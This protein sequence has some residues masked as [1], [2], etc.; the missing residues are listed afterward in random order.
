MTLKPKGAFNQKAFWR[1]VQNCKADLV[2]LH[3]SVLEISGGEGC[4]EIFEIAVSFAELDL[5]DIS[6]LLPMYPKAFYEMDDSDASDAIRIGIICHERPE[7][8][9]E[10][11]KSRAKKA[12][13]VIDAGR[14]AAFTPPAKDKIPNGFMGWRK[15]IK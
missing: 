2:S 3:G 12:K 4:K 6:E 13:K 8:V 5:M 9:L 10:L 15:F 11:L 14:P 7:Q 1:H